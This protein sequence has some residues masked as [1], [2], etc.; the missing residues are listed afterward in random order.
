[1]APAEAG[2]FPAI[3]PAFP[4]S[5][6]GDAANG[7]LRA[8]VFNVNEEPLVDIHTSCDCVRTVSNI[9]TD[10]SSVYASPAAANGT[11][12]KIEANV[13]PASLTANG[14]PPNHL[15][16]F[17]G[18]KSSSAGTINDFFGRLSN[19]SQFAIDGTAPTGATPTER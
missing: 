2:G 14:G 5:F 1:V 10:I 15:F 3:S 16:A 13:S 9:L 12:T 8:V 11:F 6:S 18:Y 7:S 17:T 19:G 4:S